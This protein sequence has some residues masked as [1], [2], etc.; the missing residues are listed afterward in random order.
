MSKAVIKSAANDQLVWQNGN[1]AS[2]MFAPTT[3]LASVVCLVFVAGCASPSN[4]INSSALTAE[5]EPME[6]STILFLRG[7]E[8][9]AAFRNSAAIANTR[10]ISASSNPLSLPQANK[11]LTNL[12]VPAAAIGDEEVSLDTYLNDNRVAGLLVIKDGAVV[13]EEYRLGNTAQSRWISFSVAKSVVAMLTGAAIQD[14]YIKNLDEKVTDYLPRLKNSS[15]DD[16]S[17]R[18]L[19]QMASGVAWNEDYADPNSDVA[20]ANYETLAL[21]EHLRNKERA[22]KPGEVFN[23]NTAETNLAGTL[24]RSAIGNNLSTYLQEKIWG[25]FGMADDA[26]WQLT[27]AGG[28]EFGGCCIN[29]TLRDYGRIGLFALADGVL[30]DGTRVLPEGW[31]AASTTPSKGY[32]GYGYFW[33]LNPDGS[34]TASGIFGQSI[35]INP[36][37][38]VVIAVH[39]AWNEAD[40]EAMWEHLK[41]VQDMLA[42]M[43]P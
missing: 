38:N 1:F 33:W 39:S 34:Y 7:E 25:P 3:L 20:A 32:D 37:E 27:E 40:G 41:R 36:Q 26:S 28:G 31:M 19:L 30:A 10:H 6:A 43:A 29:A 4:E 23:Y 2:T 8:Q 18:D 35:Y 12:R 5:A 15:Y 16:S 17:I 42:T 24:L 14:G 22:A 9:I 13:L 21:Y 11:Q